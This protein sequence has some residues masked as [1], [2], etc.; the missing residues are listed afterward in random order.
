MQTALTMLL[1]VTLPACSL[2]QSIKDTAEKTEGLV[3]TATEIAEESKAI[4]SE[5]QDEFTNA[6]LE[7]D[8]DK[9]G[10]TSMQEWLAYLTALIMGGGAVTAEGRRRIGVRN[11]ESDA[12]K[13]L[14]EAEVANLKTRVDGAT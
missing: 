4:L 5:A 13:S 8:T 6:K 11:A 2:V 10:S 7:A 3:A 9:D 12:R 1:L 14:L